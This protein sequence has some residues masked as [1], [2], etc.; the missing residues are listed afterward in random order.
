MRKVVLAAVAA[1]ALAAASTANAA[2]TVTNSSGVSAPVNVVNTPTQSTIDFGQNPAPSGSFSGWFEFNN[3]LSGLYS[4]IVSTSTPFASI[5]DAALSGLGGSPTIAS[6]S[7]SGNSLSL[8]VNFLGAG[9]YRFSF[10]GNAPPN[11]GV[12]NGNLTFQPVP[13]PATWAMMLVG[14]AGIGFAMRRRSKPV[15]A[16]VA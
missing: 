5:T 9:D 7:G 4:V 14:F 8:L 12:V 1:T 10:G 2:I 15:L 13:E 11:G 3:D 6:A 16:Q